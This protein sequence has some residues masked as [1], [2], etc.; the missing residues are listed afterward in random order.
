MGKHIEFDTV[1]TTED[2]TLMQS[3]NF[4]DGL[5]QYETYG[6]DFEY[7]R[8]FPNQKRVW[9]VIDGEDDNLW[10]IAGLHFVNRVC[11]VISDQ[12]WKSELDYYM[13][14]ELV[15]EENDMLE[16]ACD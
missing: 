15:H 1:F 9:T 16:V 11:Y 14:C 5:G 13:W 4:E 3:E 6:E 10:I 12:E 7:V 8:N 2:V